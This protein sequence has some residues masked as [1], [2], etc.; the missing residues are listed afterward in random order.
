MYK[1]V[2]ILGN[3][4]RN[5]PALIE[6]LCSLN[7]PI[8]T[9]WMAA[10]LLPENSPVFIGRPGIFGQRAANIATQK[11]THLYCFGARLDGEQVAYDYDRFAPNAQIYV[12]DI[13]EAEAQKFPKR[14]HVSQTL[15]CRDDIDFLPSLAPPHR[16][17]LNWCKALYARFRPELDGWVHETMDVHKWAQYVNPFRLMS[18]LHEFSHPDDVFALGSS[19]NA[20]TVFFQAYKVKAGQRI[21][22]VCTI[23]AMGADIP[24]ALGSALASGRRTI[25]VTGDGGFAMNAQELETIRRLRLPIIFFVMNNGGY[26]SIRVGQLARFGRVTGANPQSGLTLPSIE[27]IAEAYRFVYMPLRGMDLSNFCKCLDFAPMIVEV[28]V[29]PDWQQLPRV[30]ASG[31]PIRTD[32]MQDMT[33]KIDD[34]QALMEWD[35]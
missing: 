33:P 20:P 30:M 16:D 10:D 22:N 11:A 27:A 32:D 19:G 1:P 5:N 7:I 6:H 35:G 3:G 25:C 18:L 14:Y 13:D 29:D 2:I 15:D 12:Y 4:I 34:L 23:G 28:F 26:N 8:C 9:T 31:N 24:M 21:S 17:W